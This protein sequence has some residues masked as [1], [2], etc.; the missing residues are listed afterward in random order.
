MV[1]LSTICQVLGLYIAKRAKSKTIHVESPVGSHFRIEKRRPGGIGLGRCK[2]KHSSWYI[3]YMVAETADL[4]TKTPDIFQLKLQKTFRNRFRFPYSLFKSLVIA[5]KCDDMFGS[6]SIN[7]S[8]RDV[9]PVEL[10][11]LGV[12]RVIGRGLCF[13]DVAEYCNTSAEIHRVFF[14]HFCVKFIAKYRETYLTPP[15]TDEQLDR[16]MR[17]YE[18]GGFAGCV[19]STD[20]TH[21]PWDRCPA[22][23]RTIYKG[24]EGYPT[25]AYEVTVDHTHKILNVTPGTYGARNDKTIVRFDGFIN[26]LRR[27]SVYVNKSYMLEDIHGV[28]VE[29]KDL[30]VICDN[31]YHRWKCLQPPMKVSSVREEILYSKWLES[32]RK[33]VECTFGILKARFRILKNPIIPVR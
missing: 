2:F 9:V 6:R 31:G 10:K 21:I 23:L 20:C 32:T 4:E 22:Q 30:N 29:S 24:K 13:D 3:Q 18:R 5:C 26:A 25:I 16:I 8:C 14:H 1:C 17:M 27:I 7:A 15:T 33:D 28:R 12:L 11:I 19:G